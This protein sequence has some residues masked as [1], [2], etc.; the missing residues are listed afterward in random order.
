MLCL[1]TLTL[2]VP[3][4]SVFLIEEVLCVELERTAMGKM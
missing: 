4:L 3:F 1:D 2:L